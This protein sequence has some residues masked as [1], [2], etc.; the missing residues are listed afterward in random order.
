MKLRTILVALTLST[1]GLVVPTGPASAVDPIV[2]TWPGTTQLNPT[3]TPYVIH[4]DTPDLTGLQ[5]RVNGDGP[6]KV[7]AGGDLVP[8]FT[9]DGGQVV[10]VER[11]NVSGQ[12][13]GLVEQRV[14]EVY[15]GF[16]LNA[17]RAQDAGPQQPVDFDFSMSPIGEDTAVTWSVVDPADETVLVSGASTIVSGGH[18]PFGVFTLPAGTP[19]GRYELR[20]HVA[21][22]SQTYGSL[23]TELRPV[24]IRWD[25]HGDPGAL[26]VAEAALYPARDGYLDKTDITIAYPL[27]TTVPDLVVLSASGTVVKHYDAAD[28][29]Y[30]K[31]QWGPAKSLPLGRYT[32][33]LTTTDQAGNIATVDRTVRLLAGALTWATWKHTFSAR[34]TLV[35]QY[36]GACSTLSKK[37]QRRPKGSLGYYSQTRCARDEDSG[38]S[39]VN[40]VY[41]PAS[42]RGDYQD[43]RL[44]VNGGPAAG[45]RNAYAVLYYYDAKQGEYVHRVQLPGRNGKHRGARMHKTTNLVITDKGRAHLIW[46]LGL[47]SGSRYDAESFTVEI[48]YQK[49]SRR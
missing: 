18:V 40:G 11:C 33:R 45:A 44:T 41:L 36:V 1:V 24:V 42:A 32:V 9:E 12:N 29:R 27:K 3:T 49:L 46:S 14:I 8:A 6:T 22:D 37:P 10:R 23:D 43:F 39:T 26:R 25:T 2:L 21:A 4:A 47:T 31:I 19:D 16:R 15:S 20:W 35:S 38:V 5:V 48:G 13:C 17:V 28:L 30:R 7:T 34:S